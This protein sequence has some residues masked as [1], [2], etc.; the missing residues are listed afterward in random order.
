MYK[1]AMKLVTVCLVLISLS[2]QA[3]IA[4]D[5]LYYEGRSFGGS[6]AQTVEKT[7]EILNSIQAISKQTS[8]QK[9]TLK[10]RSGEPYPALVIVPN[11]QSAL[12]KEAYRVQQAFAGLPLVISPYDLSKGSAAFFDPSGKMLGVSYRFVLGELNDSSYLHE[13][14]HATTQMKVIQGQFQLWA[15]VMKSDSINYMSTMNRDAYAR[16]ASLDE[17]AA[18]ALS[19]KLVSKS[20]IDLKKSLSDLDFLKSEEAN[21]LANSLVHS[22][23]SGL[24]LAKQ[25]KDLAQKALTLKSIQETV[26]LSIGNKSNNVLSTVF[27]MDSYSYEFEAGKGTDVAKPKGT[28]YRMYWNQNYTPQ[29]LQNRL[30]AIADKSQQ[31]ENALMQLKKCI[32]EVIE[33]VDLKKTDYVCIERS[34]QN[35][36]GSL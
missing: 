17:I 25:S 6:H 32:R 11:Q 33:S 10:N 18:T 24:S 12:N 20:L 31:A 28:E 1:W 36:F 30:M 7:E 35:A 5:V 21:R 9:I 16:F 22:I 29:D 13:L 8:F 2:T 26:R 14:Y 19:V 4:G 23:R 27:K 3:Q 15:G 34:Y